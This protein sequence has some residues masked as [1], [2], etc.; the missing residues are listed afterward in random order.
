MDLYI[1]P[2]LIVSIKYM[3]QEVKLACLMFDLLACTKSVLKPF[4]IP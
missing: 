2:D 1:G 4:S 3:R